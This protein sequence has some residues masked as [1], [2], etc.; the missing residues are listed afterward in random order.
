MSLSP[1]PKAIIFDVYD[2]LFANSVGRW[3]DAFG[4]IAREQEL[5]ISGRELWDRWKRYEVEFR[6]NRTNLVSPQDNPP[7]KSYE[8]AWGDCFEKVFA[9]DGIRGDAAWAARRS[10]EHMS[11]RDPF[12]E[13]GEAIPVL[14]ERVRIGI[15]SNADDGFLRPLLQRAS[16]PIQIVESSESARVYK[17]HPRAFQHILA[18]LDLAPDEAWYVGDHPFDDILGAK[19]VGMGA[20]WINRSRSPFKGEVAPDLEIHDL[21]QLVGLLPE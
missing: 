14:A 6:A 20:V 19:S 4:A 11:R 1:S 15:F 17:P 2:T 18:K 16:L 3:H 9:E 7:F 21:R 13:T 8:Q 5:G 10:V 12:A